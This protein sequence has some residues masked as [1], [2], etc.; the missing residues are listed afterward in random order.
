VTLVLCAIVGCL[1]G[2]IP[3]AYLVVKLRHG[4]DVHAEGSRNVGAN[5]AW[6]TTG[7]RRTGVVVLLLDALK[8]VAA[9]AAGGLVAAA[10][11][12]AES[13]W[14]QSL[15]LLGA[16]AGH[17]YNPWLSLGAGHLVGGKGLATAAGGFAVLT[18]LLLP[19]WGA[20]FVL[21]R[22]AFGAWRGAR[23]TI[24]GNVAATALVPF[25]A[26]AVYGTAAFAVVLGFAL[27]VL[28]KHVGQMR[29]LLK[30]AD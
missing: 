30:R 25:A 12:A 4:L 18:P 24:P 2:S 13:F 20:L 1:I 27:L 15:A 5:N 17:N 6:R 9:V 3:T 22:G 10:F 19:V 7:S 29:A 8:G 16:I 26:W 23:D 14:P 11:G 21:G 28:P